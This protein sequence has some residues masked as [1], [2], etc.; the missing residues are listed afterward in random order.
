MDDIRDAVTINRPSNKDS[1]YSSYGDDHFGSIFDGP[2]SVVIPSSVSRM[3]QDDSRRRSMDFS[4]PRRTSLGGRSIDSRRSGAIQRADSGQTVDSDTVSHDD[5]SYVDNWSQ[6]RSRSPPARTSVFENIANMF[7]RSTAES[8]V[9]TRRPSLS[10]GSTS[11]RRIRRTRSRTSSDYAIDDDMASGDERWG[12]S[13][14][15]DDEEAEQS[16]IQAE[17]T[18][19]GGSDLDSYPPTPTNLP[20]LLN[21]PIFGGETRIDMGVEFEP[22]DPPPPG[23]PSRQTIYVSD[24]DVNIRFVGYEVIRMKQALWRVCCILSF[25]ILALLGHWFPR[26]WLRWV[27]QE[28]A[29]MHIERGFVVV[30]VR[31]L[32]MYP[33]SDILTISQTAYRDIALFPVEKIDY[34]YDTSTAFNAPLSTEDVVDEKIGGLLTVDYRYARFALDPRTGLFSMVRSASLYSI[35]ENKRLL[36]GN[37]NWRD[38]SWNGLAAI[39]NGLNL[40]TRTQRSVLFGPNSLDIQ[41]KSTVSLLIDEVSPEFFGR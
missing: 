40:N 6:R 23:P 22:L 29:F 27:A 28:R 34:P 16:S 8:P 15:E 18:R 5:V 38:L 36:Y 19:E 7:G 13:S 24:E 9:Q 21:D 37:S 30:E 2:G 26:L 14:G 33:I 32:R 1:R 25:G 41:G 35:Q 17:I 39:Q 11:S 3:S 12:Y 4:R 10:R 20:L 31:R